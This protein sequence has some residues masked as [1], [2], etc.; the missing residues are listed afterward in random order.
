MSKT[1]LIPID[2]QELEQLPPIQKDEIAEEVFAARRYAK[3]LTRT[4]VASQSILL[5]LSGL[6]I[7]GLATRP[8]KR[9]YIPVDQAGRASVG[10]YLDLEHYTPDAAVAK[11][12]LSDWALFRFRR[13]RATVLKDFPK[14]YVFLE[15][16]YGQQIKEHDEKE[17]VV[18]NVLAGR[19]PENDATILAV[20]LTS[21]AKQSAGD[22][23]LTVGTA[24]I[25]LQKTF[26]RDMETHS[27]TWIIAV[28]FFLNPDQVE[29][30]S[31]DNPDYQKLNPL[32]LTLIDF[33][34]NRTNVE[35]AVKE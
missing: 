28:R 6:C 22:S 7:Y 14:N 27:Q 33:I 32:G 34:P 8:A 19:T 3:K 9:I 29:K 17:N 31:E 25:A 20:T 11:N 10:R 21:F 13:L 26:A 12:Y 2:D 4:V 23:V 16:K 5:V 1:E 24:E 18:A 35:A 15:S 30:Q